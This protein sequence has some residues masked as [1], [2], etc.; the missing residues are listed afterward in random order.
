MGQDY[1]NQLEVISLAMVECSP[2]VCI[3]PSKPHYSLSFCSSHD[4]VYWAI[5]NIIPPISLGT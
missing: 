1:A 4:I 2:P 5:L 3:A